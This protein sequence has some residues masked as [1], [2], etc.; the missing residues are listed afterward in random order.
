MRKL[1]LMLGALLISFGLLS[2]L[3]A[4][5]L[6]GLDLD[7]LCDRSPHILRGEVVSLTPGWHGGR[8]LTAVTLRVERSLAGPATRGDRVTFYRLGGEVG[9]IGQR[10]LGEAS[11]RKGERVIVFLQR[12]GGR[13]VVTGMVQGKMRVLD[14]ARPG[15][16]RRVV[17]AVGGF[18]LRGGR[19]PLPVPTTLPDLEARVQARLRA[20]HRP[21]Q[22]GRP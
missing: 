4:T 9:G 2:P 3:G 11:F 15:G 12:V 13:L 7:G 8:I 20:T 5:V 14:A 6:V 22:G 10:V 19:H 18:A 16:T 17:S 1:P 21:G